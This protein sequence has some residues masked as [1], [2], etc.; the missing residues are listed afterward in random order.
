M[1]YFDTNQMMKTIG[2]TLPLAILLIEDD[3]DRQFLTDLYLQYRSLLYKEAKAFFGSAL[4]EIEDAVSNSAVRMCKYCKHLQ[5]TPCNKRV[6]YLVKIVRS[7]CN[8][9]LAELQKQNERRDWFVDSETIEGVEDE[10]KTH[11]IVFSRAY[12]DD[13][14]KSFAGL[15][16][17]DKELIRM[18]HIDM[19]DYEEIA[20]MLN[21][22]E[23]TARTAVSR[24]KARMENLAQGQ[25]VK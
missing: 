8:T 11:G 23:G 2:T 17:R 4:S 9:R 19:M 21:I 6:F 1:A 20:E 10:S 12:A 24:A 25:R 22:S 7:V 14:L 3:E 15:S 5:A 16:K 18:R 13:L